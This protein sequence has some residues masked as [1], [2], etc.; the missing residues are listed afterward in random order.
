MTNG[1]Q[2]GPGENGTFMG[3]DKFG[4]QYF[5]NRIDKIHGRHRWVVYGDLENYDASDIPA[6]WHSWLSHITD[7]TPIEKPFETRLFKMEHKPMRASTMG[8]YANYH[9]P[10]HYLNPNKE[11]ISKPRYE[12]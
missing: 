11:E 1:M 4:N 3:Q 10:G 9:N 2:F 6:E 8:F 5:E 12:S 7:H